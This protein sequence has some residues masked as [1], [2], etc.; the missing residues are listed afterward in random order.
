MKRYLFVIALASLVLFGCG[1]RHYGALDNLGPWEREEYKVVAHFAS[2]IPDL[3]YMYS[4]DVEENQ[5]HRV[6]ERFQSMLEV[7]A[8][9]RSQASISPVVDLFVTLEDLTPTFDLYLRAPE[10]SQDRYAAAPGVVVPAVA[11]THQVARMLPASFIG[12]GH[13]E[14]EGGGPDVPYEIT[15]TV[16]LTVAVEIRLEGKTLQQETVSAESVEIVMYWE[17]DDWAYSYYDVLNA[18]MSN[19]IGKIDRILDRALSR[20]A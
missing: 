16:A 10:S 20:P 13:G 1:T 9:H 6:N 3:Y 8:A 2:Q 14:A 15:K 12:D 19:A 17:Y 7:Y 18:A 5:R 4:K 11:E